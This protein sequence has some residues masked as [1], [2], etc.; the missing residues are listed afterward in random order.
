M[1]VG[2]VTKNI[3]STGMVVVYGLVVC[4]YIIVVNF[5]LYLLSD[6]TFYSRWSTYRTSF[7][8][9][10][11]YVLKIL[12]R[13]MCTC[14]VLSYRPTWA[15]WCCS[16]V[17]VLGRINSEHVNELHTPEPGKCHAIEFHYLPSLIT[18]TTAQCQ[19]NPRYLF[20]LFL[21]CCSHMHSIGEIFGVL[22]RLSCIVYTRLFRPCVINGDV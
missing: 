1:I 11:V 2:E 22:L 9:L 14:F 19:D 4:L 17:V 7:G 21:C 16:Q 13:C 3:W 20:Y 12:L 5:W 8:L 6:Q 10:L 15:Y 18:T